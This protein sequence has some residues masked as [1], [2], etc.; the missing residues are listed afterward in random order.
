MLGLCVGALT[1]G[2]WLGN[3][4]IPSAVADFVSINKPNA[5]SKKGVPATNSE[6]KVL[7]FI[8]H[9]LAKPFLYRTGT[10]K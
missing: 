7:R 10:A 1:I 8:N 3:S 4:A 2:A 9:S 6:V 5:T